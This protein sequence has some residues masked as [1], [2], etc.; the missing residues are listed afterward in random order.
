VVEQL[1]RQPW[2]VPLDALITPTGIR[3]FK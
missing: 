3:W 1:A 2:D